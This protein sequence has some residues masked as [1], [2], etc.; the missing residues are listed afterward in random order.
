MINFRELANALEAH[1]D[2]WLGRNQIF[3]GASPAAIERAETILGAPL[4]PELKGFYTN[5]NGL[6][7]D[8]MYKHSTTF[9]ED[10]DKE[11]TAELPTWDE[12]LR[13]GIAGHDY[14]RFD[15]R[16]MILPLEDVFIK[17]YKG[18]EEKSPFAVEEPF[19]SA[20]GYIS[21]KEWEEELPTPASESF[22]FGEKIY[23]SEMAF[24]AQLR[25]F[26]AFSSDDGNLILLESGQSNPMLLHLESYWTNFRPKLT[27]PLSQYLQHVA[28]DFGL[29]DGRHEYFRKPKPV[30][31]SFNVESRL[32]Q[33]IAETEFYGDLREKFQ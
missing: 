18:I 32:A 33:L 8:W 10:Y 17:S 26:D 6:A 30:P 1:P 31:I 22:L 14:I 4:H 11:D 23:E 21:D 12:L 3:P 27:L 20:C 15:G 7:I 29:R 5:H 19:A 28:Y 2:I 13:E 24:R 25:Y 16:I 9:Q